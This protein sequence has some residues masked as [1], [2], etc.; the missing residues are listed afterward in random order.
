MSE[1]VQYNNLINNN[2]RKKNTKS[3]YFTSSKCNIRGTDYKTN[4]ITKQKRCNSKPKNQLSMEQSVESPLHTEQQRLTVS[5][6][7]KPD[8]PQSIPS[9]KCDVTSEV[10]FYTLFISYRFILLVRLNYV[11]NKMYN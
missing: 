10:S 11:I 6:L 9:S 3:S 5:E 1:K 8:I 2:I 7:A 4:T